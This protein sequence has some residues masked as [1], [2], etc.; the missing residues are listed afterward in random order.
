MSWIRELKVGDEFLDSTGTCLGKVLLV[1]DKELIINWLFNG[2]VIMGDVHV[3]FK[4]LPHL[5]WI[6]LTPLTKEL[7]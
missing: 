1:N 3:S 7:L 2:R 6:K 5:N 4:R